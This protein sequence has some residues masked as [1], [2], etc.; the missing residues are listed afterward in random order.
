MFKYLFPHEYTDS[1]FSI[2]YEKLYQ[3]GYQAII[4][5]IDNTLVHH[6]EDSTNDVDELFRFLHNIGFKTLV[7]TDNSEER[8]Q[9]FLSNIALYM[10]VMLK[11]RV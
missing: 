9:K 6:G 4:F 7:L 11:N 5:D 3:K 8:T 10:Y 2:D 1:V